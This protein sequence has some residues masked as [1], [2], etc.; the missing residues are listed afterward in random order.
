MRCAPRPSNGPAHWVLTGNVS[1]GVSIPL[2]LVDCEP[3]RRWLVAAAHEA[4][5]ATAARREALRTAEAEA[6]EARRDN[7]FY[8]RGER[9][10]LRRD[11]AISWRR[12]Q[13][14]ESQTMQHRRDGSLLSR[15]ERDR[16]EQRY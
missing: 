3:N 16:Y 12:T 7:S 2:E 10:Q 14:W 4:A 5:V 9:E 6:V 11:D 15:D 13:A 1:A 8:P